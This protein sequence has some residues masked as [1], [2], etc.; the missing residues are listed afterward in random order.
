MIETKNVSEVQ[1]LRDAV[2]CLEKAET[3]F[4][5]GVVQRV[6]QC[7]HDGVDK[8]LAILG[9]DPDDED[10]TIAD[11]V[12][13]LR[14]ARAKLAQACADNWVRLDHDDQVEEARRLLFGL[15]KEIHLT[16]AMR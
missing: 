6:R 4:L 5:R 3:E 12:L 8:A 16:L 9:D 1:R 2:A 11:A 13:M 7:L 15:C 10:S 14:E